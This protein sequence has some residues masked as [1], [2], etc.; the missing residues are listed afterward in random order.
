[1]ADFIIVIATAAMLATP[2]PGAG[3]PPG[4]TAATTA[5]ASVPLSAPTVG[6]RTYP[7]A[8]SCEQATAA[9]VARPNTRLVCVPVE[10]HAGELVSAY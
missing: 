6:F 7:D 5:A 2:A 10:P 1:M 4:T 8:A 3:A 9:L